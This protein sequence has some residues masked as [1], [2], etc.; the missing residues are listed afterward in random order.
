MAGDAI[1]AVFFAFAR[2]P[3]FVLLF[4]G[5]VVDGVLG[6]VAAVLP[7]ARDLAVFEDAAA[8]LAVFAVLVTTFVALAALVFF[9]AAFAVRGFSAADF[10]VSRVGERVVLP[11]TERAKLFPLYE[12]APG[13]RMLAGTRVSSFRGRRKGIRLRIGRCADEGQARKRC[14]AC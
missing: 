10:D 12:Y 3:D 11:E 6:C 8:V 2:T 9:D 14:A 5:A 4:L 7:V 13:S 1:V